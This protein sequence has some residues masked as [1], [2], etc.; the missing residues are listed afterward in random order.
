MRLDDLI[1]D[2][3]EVSAHRSVLICVAERAQAADWTA[4]SLRRVLVGLRQV[5][6]GHPDGQSVRLSRVR[7]VLGA[8]PGSRLART[9]L[10]DLG[11]LVDDTVPAMRTW[12]DRQ[13]EA[14][15]AGYRA[16]VRAWLLVLSEG[17]ERARPR[18]TATIYAYFG[19]VRPH[20]LAWSGTRGQLREVTESDVSQVLDKLRGHA[21]TGTF[22]SLRSLFQFAKRRRLVFADPTR[23]LSAGCA[24][25]RALL[26][27]TDEEIGAVQA[28]AVSPAQ[29][30]IIALAALY[31]ARAKAIRELTL[32][33]ID[34]GRRLIRIG[35]LEHRLSEL[36]QSALVTWLEHRRR[37]WPRT[38]NRHALVSGASAIGTGPISDYYLSWH[39]LLQG[40]Q[41]E[42]I[43]GD[44]I[45]QEAL[46]TGA[47]PLHL[48]TAFNLSPKTAIGYANIA[49]SLLERPIEAAEAS[50]EPF[51]G[52][53]RPEPSC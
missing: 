37:Q 6:D 20:L 28:V 9:V 32:D 38:H 12:I 51:M 18:A 36:A 40:V 41:L 52:P 11:L 27:M 46:A 8:T 35:G 29:R 7:A 44:R 10:D 26:P 24:P 31:A 16:E 43:R 13:C 33:D 15:P 22:T 34:L 1:G 50:P 47:D 49:R 42:Q 2:L 23:R 39:L 30:L 53:Q 17:D 3:P 45:L 21:L 25:T 5:L 14:L 4:P 48:V 19:R